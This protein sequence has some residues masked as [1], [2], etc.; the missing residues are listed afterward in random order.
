MAIKVKPALTIEE[1]RQK[2]YSQLRKSYNELAETYTKMLDSDILLCPKCNEFRPKKE[3][4]LDTNYSIG[5]FPVCKKCLQLMSEQRTSTMKPVNETKESVQRV[6]RFMNKPYHDDLFNGVYKRKVENTITDDEKREISIFPNYMA[7]INSLPQYGG[8]TWEDS[9]FGDSRSIEEDIDVPKIVKSTV[10]DGRKRFG[11]GYTDEELMF[12]E[13]EYRDWTARYE[14]QTKA[15]EKVFKNLAMVELQKDKA[16]KKNQPT[17][18]LD[19]TYQDWLE[20]GN[21]K[22]KQNTLDTFSDAQTL[23]TLIQ[24]YEEERPLPQIDPELEDVDKIGL[25]IDTFF[26]GHIC[27]AL[28]IKNRFFNIYDNVMKKYTV[29]PPHYDEDEDSEDIFNRIFG[30]RDD[31]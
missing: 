10:A 6:L 24:K 13:N 9:E 17:K 21:L 15:Q 3:F 29:T 12:L 11:T 22:P 20:A 31:G 18:D 4:Y 16:I 27:K 19:K 14:C 26:K 2:T 5:V 30:D 25:Y 7:A 23:G 8:E 1:I 28:G